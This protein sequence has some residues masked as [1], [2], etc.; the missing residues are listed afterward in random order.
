M[1]GTYNVPHRLI[2]ILVFSLYTFYFTPIQN[3]LKLFTNY[4]FVSVTNQIRVMLKLY[5]PKLLFHPS[6]YKK[7]SLTLFN[8]LFPSEWDKSTKPSFTLFNPSPSSYKHFHSHFLTNYLLLSVTNHI[9]AKKITSFTLFFISPSSYKTP[10]LHI[11]TNYLPVFLSVTNQLTLQIIFQT[12]NQY[13]IVINAN[14]IFIDFTFK[15]L[16]IDIKITR[17]HIYRQSI[18][19]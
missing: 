10:P 3:T 7:S 4:L 19:R 5:P 2:I 18:N 14:N 9:N 6:S 15:C 1:T 17:T 8:E 13:P 12:A 16:P 11:L